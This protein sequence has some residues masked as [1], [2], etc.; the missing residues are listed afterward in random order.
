MKV[1][2]RWPCFTGIL[3]YVLGLFSTL[4]ESFLRRDF[5]ERFYTQNNFI[6][7]LIV[8]AALNVL[9][10]IFSTFSLSGG[11]NMEGDPLM[12]SIIKL[13]CLVVFFILQR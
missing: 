11:A 6:G 4:I 12:W 9:R 2:C 7:G 8:M 13:Y 3:I 10:I 1:R 5:G